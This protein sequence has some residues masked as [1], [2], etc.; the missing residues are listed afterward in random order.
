MLSWNCVSITF[1]PEVYVPEELKFFFSTVSATLSYWQGWGSLLMQYKQENAPLLFLHLGD[2]KEFQGIVEFIPVH[3]IWLKISVH[4]MVRAL[5]KCLISSYVNLYG[6][7]YRTLSC[8]LFLFVF[9]S[10]L[11]GVQISLVIRINP[12]IPKLKVG[13]TKDRIQCTP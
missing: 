1:F 6:I 9:V 10:I 3:H 7:W 13:G 4:Q 2:G 8:N 5:P 12:T 11:S